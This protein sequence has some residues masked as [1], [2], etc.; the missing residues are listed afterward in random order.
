MVR[1][2]RAQIGIAVVFIA[3]MFLNVV[4]VLIAYVHHAI[5]FENVKDLLITLLAVYSGP[6]AIVFAGV[7]A[8]RGVALRRP[9]LTTF[10]FA[11]CVSI[12]W[13]LFLVGGSVGLV[14]AAFGNSAKEGAVEEFTSYL[15]TI[16][17]SATFMVS[18]ALTYFFAR[19]E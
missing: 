17:S 14:A 16:S 10:W 2:Q 13:N 4:A 19:G 11:V 3:G 12:A 1:M 18:G 7:F 15:R 5:Y 9:A 8:K 6:L